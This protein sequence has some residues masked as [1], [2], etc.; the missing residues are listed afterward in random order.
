LKPWKGLSYEVSEGAGEPR[1]SIYG[2]R[3]GERGSNRATGEGYREGLRLSGDPIRAE[4]A[5]ERVNSVMCPWCGDNYTAR[6]WDPPHNCKE[7]QE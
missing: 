7:D 4:G 5:G 3:V 1:R 6:A 2:R